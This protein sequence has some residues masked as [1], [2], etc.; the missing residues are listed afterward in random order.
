LRLLPP[1]PF[2]FCGARAVRVPLDG[3]LKL[4]G[5]FYRAPIALVRQRVVLRFDRDHVW[6]RHAA[7]TSRTIRAVGPR[8]LVPATTT[9]A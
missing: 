6:I 9:A 3:Y 4:G 7:P 5:N 1:A 8:P 2:D